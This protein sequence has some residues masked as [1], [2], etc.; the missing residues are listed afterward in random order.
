VLPWPGSAQHPKE[1]PVPGGGAGFAVATIH[2]SAVLRA[3]DRDEA[4]N[5][6]VADLKVVAG[7]L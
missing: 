4:F 5:G 6:L 2:P 1:F 7:Q 3:D